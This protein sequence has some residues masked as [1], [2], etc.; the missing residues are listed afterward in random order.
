M[1]SRNSQLSAVCSGSVGVARLL[2]C[3]GIPPGS[4]LSCEFGDGEG[5]NMKRGIS[6]SSTRSSG[7]NSAQQEEEQDSTS[8]SGEGRDGAPSSNEPSK[9]S[10]AAA[11]DAA[12]AE[13]ANG[14]A[15]AQEERTNF[16]LG[17]AGTRALTSHVQDL[18]KGRRWIDRVRGWGEEAGLAE[19]SVKLALGFLDILGVSSD[20]SAAVF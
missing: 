8:I 1:L 16:L 20:A 9:K 6:S 4:S 2:G 17:M 14:E 3:V 13:G 10:G 12:A 18:S 11:G 7:R 19:P 15:A 5:I